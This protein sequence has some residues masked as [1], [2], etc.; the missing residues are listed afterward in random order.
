MSKWSV[1]GQ[2]L[3]QVDILR[4]LRDPHC[5]GL[6]TLCNYLPLDGDM[7][8]RY[9]GRVTPM[10]RLLHIET[11]AQLSLELVLPAPLSQ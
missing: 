11:G 5:P 7:T 9:D 6:H 2:I 10:I 1:V 4:R 8:C 3:Q